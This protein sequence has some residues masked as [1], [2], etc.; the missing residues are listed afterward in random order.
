MNIW[1]PPEWH[2]I[3]AVGTWVAAVGTIAAVIVALGLARRDTKSR[4]IERRGDIVAM[5]SDVYQGKRRMETLIRQNIQAPLYRIPDRSFSHGL[6]RL[7]GDGR[8]TEL[9]I[10][11]LLEYANKIAEI[12]RGLDRAGDAHAAQPG[13][14]SHLSDEFSRNQAKANEVLYE[15]S[16]RFGDEPLIDA[17]ERALYRIVLVYSP[18]WKRVSVK[19]KGRSEKP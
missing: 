5:C 9:E 19:C 11:I 2:A 15:E 10:D 4:R 18:W 13:G 8:L 1:N 3:E 7:I 12:N 16:N 17:T 14:S 6:S